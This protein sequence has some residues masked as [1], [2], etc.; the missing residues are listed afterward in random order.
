MTSERSLLDER[1]LA[2]GLETLPGWRVDGGA[3]RRD[4]PFDSYEAGVGFAV[5][6]ALLA[7]RLDH[8]PDIEIVWG[9]VTLRWMTHDAGGITAR[10]LDAAHAVDDLW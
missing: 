5:S 3:L 6:I 1:A 4:Y 10:D 8:H 9:R 7:Q 2:A